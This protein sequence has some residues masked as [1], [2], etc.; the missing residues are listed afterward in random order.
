MGVHK[1]V[2]PTYNDNSTKQSFYFEQVDTHIPNSPTSK[3]KKSV[4]KG[5][6]ISKLPLSSPLPKI[7][8]NEEMMVFMHKYIE[9]TVDVKSDGDYGYRA[10]SALLDRG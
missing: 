8:H 2:K 6:C 5:V 1:K 10:I 9:R 3:S 7:K 4:F